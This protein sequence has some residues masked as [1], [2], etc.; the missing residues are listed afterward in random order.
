MKRAIY[1]LALM[2]IPMAAGAVLEE[3]EFAE[4]V[5]GKYAQFNKALVGKDLT[6]FA[7]LCTSDCRIQMRPRGPRLSLD[8]FKKLREQGF[9]TASVTRA[10][11]TVD[12]V[13]VFGDKAIV[14]VTWIGDFTARTGAAARTFRT[15]QKMEDTWTREDADWLLSSS[16]IRSTKTAHLRPSPSRR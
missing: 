16:I 7:A 13:K 9:R 12:S 3:Q 10:R 1:I 11:T 14:Q 6:A 5:A 2:A 8:Q 4:I 15:V